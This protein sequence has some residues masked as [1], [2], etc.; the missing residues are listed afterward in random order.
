MIVAGLFTGQRLEIGLVA[1]SPSV[2][3]ANDKEKRRLRNTEMGNR[4]RQCAWLSWDTTVVDFV[5]F[6]MLLM[7]WLGYGA[8]RYGLV[9]HGLS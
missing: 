9:R 4:I 3:G 5:V 1:A 7:A 8:V 2:I 6:L